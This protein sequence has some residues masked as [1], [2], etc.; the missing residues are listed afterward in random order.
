MRTIHFVLLLSYILG[1]IAKK[2]LK[3]RKF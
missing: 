1:A 2:S 3:S